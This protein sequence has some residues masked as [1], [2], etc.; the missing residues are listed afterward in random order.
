MIDHIL[1]ICSSVL[2][3][4]FLKLVKF[5]NILK[6]NLKIY[7]KILKLFKYKNASDFRKEKLILN[8]SK[9]L[10]I[11]SVKIFLILFF[12]LIFIYTSSLLSN[13]FLDLVFSI[14]GIIEYGIIFIIYHLLRK[15]NNA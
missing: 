14:L 4:E 2:I 11:L 10:F 7:Q 13:F 9:L 1:L 8:Y 12:I 5:T 3:Y 15:K 6:S